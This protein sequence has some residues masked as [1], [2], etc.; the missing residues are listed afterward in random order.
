MHA[1]AGRHLLQACIELGLRDIPEREEL[2]SEA[3]ARLWEIDENLC[4]AGLT[5]LE[6]AEHPAARKELYESCTP[7]RRT[8]PRKPPPCTERSAMM[9]R[10]NLP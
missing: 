7:R 4:R 9:S 5:E 3:E 8:A 1:V 6:R 10:Q 2:R